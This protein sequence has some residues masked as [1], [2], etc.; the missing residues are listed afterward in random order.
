[1][2]TMLNKT[3][4]EGLLYEH[5]LEK[6][7]SGPNSKTPGTEFIAGSVSI[8]TDDAG[9]N[10]VPVHFTYVTAKTAKGKDNSAYTTLAR[11]IDGS[12]SSI[13]QGGKETAAKL[14][15]DSAINL[16]EFY[17]DRNGKEELVSAKRN[18][19]GF[20]H[21]VD[22]LDPDE[23]KRNTF[24]CDMVITGVTRVDANEEKQTPEKVIVR[25]A[26]FTFRGELLPVDFSAT[27]PHAM[28]YFEGLGV[29]NQEPVFTKLWGRQESEVVVKTIV[30][31]SAFGDDSIK[32]VKST[33]KDFLI[34]GSIREP[35]VWDDETTILAS[36]LGEAMA[37][38]QTALATMKKRQEDYKASRASAP[39][40]S[41]ATPAAGS[42]VF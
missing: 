14:R 26:I 4:V 13:M 36:E 8:A 29:T 7:V 20:I 27:N 31:E 1:M 39:V 38:R 19:G 21:V 5:K 41:V 12:L 40:P 17:T 9:V 25:G 35:Y 34:T 10:I 22:E 30:E 15:I 3:H 11:I 23:N 24:E 6:K 42:F 37:A 2:K 32:E 33:R 28:N 18:E 16:N